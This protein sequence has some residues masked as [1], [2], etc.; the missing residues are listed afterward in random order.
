MR[1]LDA[2]RGGL[3]ADQR[4][5]MSPASSRSRSDSSMQELVAAAARHQI[6]LARRLAEAVGHHLQQLVAVLVAERV[7]HQTEVVDVHAEDRHRALV[8]AR[9]LRSRAPA[10]PRT[11]SG[12]GS[13][14][15]SSWYVRNATAPRRACAR[16]C[17][18]PRRARTAGMPRSSRTIDASSCTQTTWPS[19][20][21][22]PVLHAE[23]LA[24]LVVPLVLGDHAGT[25]VGMQHARSQ[26]RAR[27]TTPARVYPRSSSICGLMYI[28]DAWRR[29][30]RC[31]SPRGRSPRASGYRSS[32]SGAS[33][34]A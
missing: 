19:L 21:E 8:T 26:V 27:R 3:G 15:S 6:G 20:M 10:T 11:S 33:P 9:A 31:R 13:P 2:L 28:V 4:A 23:L 30:R 18:S 1:L 22:H 14:V 32:R 7:V 34:P 17:P 29:E 12:S 24:R 25:V 16:R 5:S